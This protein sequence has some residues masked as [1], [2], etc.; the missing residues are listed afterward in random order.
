MTG[1]DGRQL[2]RIRLVSARFRELQGLHVASIGLVNLLWS[3]GLLLTNAVPPRD[4]GFTLVSML[5][6]VALAFTGA[7]LRHY[8]ATRFGRITSDGFSWTWV[9][10]ASIVAASMAVV[11]GFAS[12]AWIFATLAGTHAWIVVR[13]FPHRMH[14]LFA[15]VAGGG[16]A[17][18][19][20]ANP[21]AP[22]VLWLAVA[23]HGAAVIPV[24]LMDHRLLSSVLGGASTQSVVI[25]E[26]SR[27]P[28]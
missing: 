28:H 20:Y 13:D 3:G 14:H 25:A 7:G 24:G 22:D 27:I 11:L 19:V 23:I 5:V 1:L 15:A 9:A 10:V 6:C 21:S 17:A 8:Y 16:G 4:I 2:S 26:A 18:L 12:A